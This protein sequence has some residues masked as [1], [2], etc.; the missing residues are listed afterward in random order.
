MAVTRSMAAR[1]TA[2][3]RMSSARRWIKRY[4]PSDSAK[5]HR[6]SDGQP[7]TSRVVSYTRRI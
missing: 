6:L 4:K 1:E 7:K 2:Q 3:E 5:R